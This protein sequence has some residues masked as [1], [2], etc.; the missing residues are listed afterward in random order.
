MLQENAFESRAPFDAEVAGEPVVLRDEVV[1]DYLALRLVAAP[2]AVVRAAARNRI[3]QL[4][5]DRLARAA[6]SNPRLTI[7][8]ERVELPDVETATAAWHAALGHAAEIWAARREEIVAALSDRGRMR[9]T[10]YRPDW[11]RSWADAMGA[12]LLA[13][14]PGLCDRFRRFGKFTTAEVRKGARGTPPAHAFFTACDALLAEDRALDRYSS[15]TRSGSGATSSTTPGASSAG[16]RKRRISNPSTTS[17]TAWR[18]RSLE[19]GAESCANAI[20]KRFHA[21]LID[22]FQDTDPVQY[23]IF[24]RIYAGRARLAV[25][26]RRPEAGDLLVP[27]RRRAHLHGGA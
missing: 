3:G 7:L 6:A 14:V 1:R 5:F 27:R 15:A 26:D 13:G 17:S 2:D 11:V 23:E 25:S 4:A 8:P 24:R 21:A 12:H 10:L 16:A 22:E 18:T 9:G 19:A 20:A